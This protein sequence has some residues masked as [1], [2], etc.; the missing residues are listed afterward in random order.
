MGS[1]FNQIIEPGHLPVNLTSLTLG[2]NYTQ[3]VPLKAYPPTLRQINLGESFQRPLDHL[4]VPASV[5]TIEIHQSYQQPIFLNNLP[6]SVNMVRVVMDYENNLY[7]INFDILFPALDGGVASTRLPPVIEI[8]FQ[9]LEDR[10][11]LNNLMFWNIDANR[12]STTK[13][14]S[15]VAISI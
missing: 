1:L 14:A 15:S 11:I 5:E 2:E 4:S 12:L 9:D 10:I 3:V 6:L 8:V 13:S 7:N